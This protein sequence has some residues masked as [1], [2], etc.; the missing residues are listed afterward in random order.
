[1]KWCFHFDE[2]VG[3][4]DPEVGQAGSLEALA[5]LFRSERDLGVDDD[6]SLATALVRDGGDGGRDFAVLVVSEDVVQGFFD[7]EMG[8]HLAADF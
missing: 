3:A 5:D 7:L 2:A 6:Q 4:G 8:H 1:L